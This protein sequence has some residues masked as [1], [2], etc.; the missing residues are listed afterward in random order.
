MRSPL[1]TVTV[2][3]RL[4]IRLEDRLQNELKRT[5]HYTVTNSGNRED[6]NF[7]SVLRYLLPSCPQWHIGTRFQFVLYLHQE[8]LYAL[9]FDDLERHSVY[10]RSAVVLLGQRIRLTQSLHLADMD[11]QTPE[12]PGRFSLRLDVYVPSQVLQTYRRV[13]HPPLPPVLSELLQTAGPLR[14]PGIT[15]LPRSYGPIRHPLAFGPLPVVAVIGPTLLRRFRAGARRASPVAQHVL[16]IVPSLP[17]RR[18][19]IG[20]SVSLRLSMLPS[21]S[22]LRARPSDLLTFEA[23]STFTFITA[24]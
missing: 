5:L 20:V 17:P 7:S 6:A 2:R 13:Y 14:S 11:V 4:K 3:T 22:R 10:S 16:V 21:P 1:G 9:R 19:E 23:T 24:R 18:S 8:L 15:R 12:T